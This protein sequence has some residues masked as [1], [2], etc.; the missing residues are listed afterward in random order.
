[1]TYNGAVNCKRHVSNVF[2]SQFETI[3]NHILK[4]CFRD[5]IK[6]LTG[7]C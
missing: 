1:M 4:E 7:T 6:M 2:K 5:M 3:I